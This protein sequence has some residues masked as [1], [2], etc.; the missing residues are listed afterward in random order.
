MQYTC[1]RSRADGVK[2][3]ALKIACWISVLAALLMMA[4]PAFAQSLTTVADTLYNPD[5]TKASGTI[6]ISNNSTFTAADGTVVPTGTVARAQVANGVF[7]VQLVPNVGSTPS[8]TSYTASYKLGVTFFSETWVVPV[9]PNPADLADVRTSPTPTPGIQLSPS[10]MPALTGDVT[11]TAGTTSTKVVQLH[12]GSQVY[13]LSGSLANGNCLSVSGFTIVGGTCG[14]TVYPS[15]GVANSTGSA[16]GTPYQ[17][18]TSP[19]NLVQLD[20]GGRLPAVNGSQLTNLPASGAGGSPGDIQANNAGSL[21]LSGI[22]TDFAGNQV[23][24]NLSVTSLNGVLKADQFSGADASQKINACLAALPSTGGTC[25]ARGIAGSQTIG[26]VINVPSFDTLLLGD[27]TFSTTLLPALEWNTS[28]TIRGTAMYQSGTASGTQIFYTATGVAGSFL[29]CATTSCTD[30]SLENI[31]LRHTHSTS[32]ENDGSVGVDLLN[33]NSSQFR[34]VFVTLFATDWS[35][36]VS[37]GSSFYNTL[38]HTLGQTAYNYEY[39]WSGNANRNTI[40]DPQCNSGAVPTATCFYIGG[41]ANTWIGVDAET[42]GAGMLGAV[43]IQGRGNHIAAPYIEGT[44]GTAITVDA[45]ASFNTYVGGIGGSTPVDNSQ[46]WQR[47]VI[48]DPGNAT[49][50]SNSA[51]ITGYPNFFSAK[52]L[53]M[54]NSRLMM[55]GPF[56]AGATPTFMQYAPITSMSRSSNV[57]TVS[58]TAGFSPTE[59]AGSKVQ[60]LGSSPAGATNFN[61]DFSIATA[62][63]STSFTFNQTAADDTA[64]NGWALIETPMPIASEVQLRGNGSSA[65]TLIS[66]TSGGAGG[67]ALL[68]KSAGGTLTTAAINALTFNATLSWAFTSGTNSYNANKV[69]LTGN[70]TSSSLA[71]T[72]AWPTGKDYLFIACQDATGSRTLAMPSNVK[73]WQPISPSPNACSYEMGEW[74]GTNIN[75]FAAMDSS[76]NNL[77][78]RFPAIRSGV[79]TNTDLNGSLALSGGTAT[80]NFTGTYTSAPICIAQDD[81]SFGGLLTKTVTTTS[82][83]VTAGATDVVD[84]ICSARN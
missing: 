49:T 19:N 81:T 60:I 38:I 33:T 47:N 56:T 21:A 58:L 5:G 6:T 25:D 18:G 3:W 59:V 40:I 24:Q 53:T 74:D 28:S 36:N 61:G 65:A 15:A 23:A 26:T 44:Y 82:L 9:T 71:G 79:S 69:T 30:D 83:T 42:S 54:A 37:S 84:Y 32:P 52:Y 34:N 31:Y 39:Y 20:S 62:T 64:T 72:S 35:A 7:S 77:G 78:N 67:T 75:I 43:Y 73:E 51:S 22:T 68:E 2:D 63:S 41:V 14:G 8:G 12:W 16:W 45:A 46:P 10:Q 1:R 48:I 50:A 11:S 27:A 17:V 70:V 13:T 76:G 66:P 4:E 29:S 55:M 80:Y 57:V